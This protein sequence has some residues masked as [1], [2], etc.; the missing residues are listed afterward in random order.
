MK[1]IPRLLDNVFCS[2]EGHMH[3]QKRGQS[4]L[5]VVKRVLYYTENCIWRIQSKNSG[6]YWKIHVNL[7][8]VYNELKGT[9]ENIICDDFFNQHMHISAI[10]T[11][12]MYKPVFTT[13]IN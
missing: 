1:Q 11:R 8:F 5:S 7:R 9:F 4:F 13:C 2:K 6:Q 3:K 12:S 10:V